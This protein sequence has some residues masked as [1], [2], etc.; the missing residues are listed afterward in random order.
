VIYLGSLSKVLAPGLR[1]G[2][3]VAPPT[4]LDRLARLR[5]VC[6]MQGDAVVEC[7]VA[8]LFEDG[9]LLRHVYRMRETYGR[10][11]TAL[12]AALHEHLPAALTFD[13]PDGGMAIW[14]HVDPAIDLDAWSATGEQRG[15]LFRGAGMFDFAGRAQPYLRIG[16][17]YHDERELAAA[18]RLMAHAL[19]PT[20]RSSSPRV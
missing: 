2:F 15:V 14:A 18:V 16:F 13:V 9:E 4:V 3:V 19:P 12:A 20:P 8:E 10:R 7:A 17:T 6:D 5:A 11:R 1:I